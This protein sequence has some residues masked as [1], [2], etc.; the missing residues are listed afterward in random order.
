MGGKK[1]P[2]IVTDVNL[3]SFIPKSNFHLT[4]NVIRQNLRK[5]KINTFYIFPARAKHLSL[6]W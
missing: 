1:S 4:V 3:K 6:D 2:I 5:G